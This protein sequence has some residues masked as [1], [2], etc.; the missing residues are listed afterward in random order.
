M[1]GCQVHG[2]G[3][4][5]SK[6]RVFT[7][8]LKCYHWQQMLSLVFLEVTGSLTSFLRK[9]LPTTIAWLLV[10]LL[11]GEKKKELHKK[12]WL[13]YFTAP[14]TTEALLLETTI[15]FVCAVTA[16]PQD[17]WVR[18]LKT[19]KISRLSLTIH[20]LIRKNKLLLL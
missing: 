4:K 11:R 2:G 9:C 18:L 7:W 19:S 8:E 6:I 3:Y 1:G 12:K 10:I 20:N 14:T 15:A 5:S 17:L 16:G 13:I